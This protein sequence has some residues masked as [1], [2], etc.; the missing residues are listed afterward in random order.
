MFTIGA[1]CL[2]FPA[3]TWNSLTSSPGTVM[4]GPTLLGSCGCDELIASCAEPL[5]E[6]LL[7]RIRVKPAEDLGSAQCKGSDP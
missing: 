3:L 7:I 5:V 1:L 6:D 4:T 2:G